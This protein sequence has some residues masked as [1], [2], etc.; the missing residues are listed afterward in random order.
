MTS[1]VHLATSLVLAAQPFTTGRRRDGLLL[2]DY[3]DGHRL[4][5]QPRVLGGLAAQ[6]AALC[7]E[8][9]AEVVIGEVAA[10]SALAVAVALQT[11]GDERPLEARG[12]RIAPKPYGVPGVLTTALSQ[13]SRVAL[14]DDV[15]GNAASLLRCAKTLRGAGHEVVGAAVIVDREQGAVEALA[16]AGVR[17]VPLVCLR[18]LK[19][20]AGV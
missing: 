10:G 16:S 12:L 9:G 7:R 1:P 11:A 2:T 18:E 15:S 8:M 19:R 14:V 5:A 4:L 13:P 17:L 20:C 3:L 6:I